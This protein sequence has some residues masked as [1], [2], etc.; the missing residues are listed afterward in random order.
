MRALPYRCARGRTRVPSDGSTPTSEGRLPYR[1]C[2]PCSYA[3]HYAVP[4]RSF[5]HKGLEQFFVADTKAGIQAAHAPKL[6]RLLARLNVSAKPEGMSLPGFGFHPLKG[7]STG[8]FS[9]SVSGH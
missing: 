2:A 3:I 9:V 6:K 5:K 8:R 1:R 7:R 4:I